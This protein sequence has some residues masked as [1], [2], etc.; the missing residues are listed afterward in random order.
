MSTDHQLQQAVLEELAWEPSVIAA[1]IGVAADKGVITLTGRVTDYPQKHA[2]EMAAH[3]V[4]GVKAVVE[5]IEVQLPV[6]TARSDAEIAA[7]AIDR[8]GWDVTIPK[9]SVQIQ[10]EDG[11]VTLSGEVDWFFQKDNASKALRHLFGVRGLSDDITVKPRVDVGN[12]SDA[13]THALHRSWF[14]DPKTV[15]VSAHGSVV[16]LTGTVHLPYDRQLA[17]ATAWSA[18]GVT[19]VENDITLV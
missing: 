2:A 13:I 9:D 17:A 6:E 7:A 8:L 19:D 18:A 15:Q 14:F 11:W 4:R 16:H 12:I 10:V 3:R 5:A 1:H